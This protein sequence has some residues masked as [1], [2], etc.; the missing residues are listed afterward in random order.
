ME[1]QVSHCVCTQIPRKVFYE[2]KRLEIREILRTLCR[3]KGV[4]LIEGEICP[5]HI[6]M[7]VSIPPKMSVAGFMEYLKGKSSLMIFQKWGNMKFAYRNR[8]FWCKGYYVT[9][10]KNTAAIKEYIAN[11][12]KQDKEADQLSM[13]DMAYDQKTYY[14]GEFP[15]YSPSLKGAAG[16]GGA[17]WSDAGVI[18]PRLLYECYG[19]KELLRVHYEGIKRYLEVLVKGDEARGDGHLLSAP[20]T[21]G[22]WLAQDGV[23]EQSMRGGTDDTFIR[24]IYY[25]NA[26]ITAAWAAGIL[27][28]HEDERTFSALADDIRGSILH[29]YYSP[30]GRLALDTQTSYVLALAFDVCPDREKL[31]ALFRERLKKDLYRM[32]SGFTGTPLMI[33]TMFENGM[34]EEAYRLIFNEKCPGWMFELN[35]GATTIWE[36]WNSLLP[37]GTISGTLM[38]SLNHYAY[39]SVAEAVYE[40]VGGIKRADIAWK[41]ARISPVPDHRVRSCHTQFDSSYGVYE[42]DWKVGEGCAFSLR[43]TVPHGCTAEICLPYSGRAPFEVGEGEHSYCYTLEKD[44]LHPFSIDSKAADL[45]ENGEAKA[46]FA[47]LLPQA[48]AMATG[49]NEEFLTMSVREMG[50]LAMF[51]TSPEKVSELDALLKEIGG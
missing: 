41:K 28:E 45:V 20:F 8:E 2:E 27:G 6:H 23:C 40:Y 24:S 21:F 38:N 7:L 39:G 35:L 50:Y 46:A 31:I 36:R 30:L 10:G 48:F 5:D 29:E 12:L 51:G 37:D 14:N 32:K 16:T 42:V 22:D 11:Q 43:V 49:E 25:L 15:M 34:E 44:I 47:R 19:D 9:V 26:V 3:W 13:R 1:L 4:E 33:R 18:V 17:V